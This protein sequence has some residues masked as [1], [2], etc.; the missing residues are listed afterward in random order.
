MSPEQK[1][2]PPLRLAVLISGGGSTLLNILE[3]I[4]EGRLNAEVVGVVASKDC[5][6]LQHAADF[7]VPSAIVER[8]QPFDA[9]DFAARITAELD[10]WQP[11]LIVFGGFLSLYL[12]PPQYRHRALN[13]HPAL[14][15]SFGGQG[16]Y[17]DR[18]HEAV[19][20]SGTRVSGCTVHLVDDEY[21]HGSIVLQKV[22]PVLTGDDVASLGERIRSA[23]RELLPLVISL[24]AEGRIRVDH[25]G[26]VHI[27]DRE[28]IS[29]L[30]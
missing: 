4:R 15:P 29:G 25:A 27:A 6:G 14:L 11:D 1:S 2:R 26:K 5:G 12:L 10:R 23:E 18:V 19:L 7:N 9:A 20:Q 8:G 16:M 28:L 13:T 3:R 30:S 17:G 21:D 24:W 22:V